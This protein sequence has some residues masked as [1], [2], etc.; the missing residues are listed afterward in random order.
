MTGADARGAIGWAGLAAGMA[1]VFGAGAV[2]NPQ[3]S[4]VLL[5]ARPCFLGSCST[6]WR[7]GTGRPRRGAD[8]KGLASVGVLPSVATFIDLPLAW[9]ALFVGLIK[10][11]ARSPLLRRHLWWLAALD[12]AVLLAWAFNPS[13]ILRPIVYFMLLAEPFAIVGALLADPPSPRLRRALE[14]TL[15]MLLLIQ[16]PSHRDSGCEVW[17]SLRSRPG[18]ALWRRGRSTRD[19]RHC[20][21]RRALDSD[22]RH[23]R[24]CAPSVATPGCVSSLRHPVPC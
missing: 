14:A 8:F 20:H 22:R 7:M 3:V 10:Q 1:I 21:H 6:R 16:T 24:P 5:V 11:R 15:L 9:G 17:R 13:E 2:L 4:F 19:F 18:N 23:R 12:L